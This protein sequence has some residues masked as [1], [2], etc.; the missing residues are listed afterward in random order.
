[1]ALAGA[2]G[3]LGM[4]VLPADAQGS[5]AK[6]SPVP[7]T[8]P[9]R[10]LGARADLFIGT[11]VDMTALANE[12]TYSARVASEFNSVTPENVM[13]WQVVEPTR[14]GL[15]FTQADKLVA[16]AQANHQRVRG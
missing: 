2:V 8:Q 5:G 15:D 4:L 3:I 7:I 1:V 12:L 9:L 11:A 13:K 16:F 10:V 6:A 14:G